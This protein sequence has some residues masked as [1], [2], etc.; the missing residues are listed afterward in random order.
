MVMV[1]VMVLTSSK[2]FSLAFLTRSLG[3]TVSRHPP[4]R[5]PYNLKFHDDGN[6]CDD[7]QQIGGI[8]NIPYTTLAIHL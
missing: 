4:Q 6:D 2:T 5:G 3:E 7:F 8:K 1:M